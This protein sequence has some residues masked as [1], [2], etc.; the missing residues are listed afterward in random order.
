MLCAAAVAAAV[1]LVA[2]KPTMA[3][4]VLGTC[5]LGISTITYTP[6]V[7]DTPQEVFQEGSEQSGLCTFV[8]PF[9]LRSFTTEFSGTLTTSCTELLTGSDSGEQTFLWSNGLTSEWSFS[10]V[11]SQTA[12]GNTVATYTGP[13]SADSEFLPGVTVIQVVTYTNLTVES[14]EENPL[15]EQS[16]TSTYTF[17]QG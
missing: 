17:L 16:G 9:G 8:L 15:T 4:V 14:C 2:P 3:D 6:G 5:P 13:L 12:S 10:S 7:T 11:T 1:F